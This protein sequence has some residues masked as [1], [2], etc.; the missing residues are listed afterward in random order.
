VLT[1][2][3]TEKEQLFIEFMVE[4][5]QIELSPKWKDSL[6]VQPMSD[7]GMGSLLLIPDNV[8]TGSK[9]LF[10][11]QISEYQFTDKDGVE[12]ITSL[13]VD[14]EGILFELDVWK[15]DYSCLLDFPEAKL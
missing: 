3:P 2:R 1:R 4:K 5:A 14:Q 6:Y 9:R 15:T 8:T 13:N 12:V 7:G 10:G 11:K